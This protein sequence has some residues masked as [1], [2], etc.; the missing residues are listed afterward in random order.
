[1]GRWLRHRPGGVGLRSKHPGVTGAK[2]PSIPWDSWPTRSRKGPWGHGS[3]HRSAKTASRSHFGA[4]VYTVATLWTDV[5]T[6]ECTQIGENGLSEPFRSICVHCCTHELCRVAR[7]P[8]PPWCVGDAPSVAT[9]PLVGK[10]GSARAPPPLGWRLRRGSNPHKPPISV[11]FEPLRPP[12]TFRV[13][14]AAPPDA[15]AGNV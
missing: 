12:R 8:Q 9:S 14:L 2:G 1:M 5:G 13:P 7:A 10:T 15:L 11:T 3:V 6:Q 4:F